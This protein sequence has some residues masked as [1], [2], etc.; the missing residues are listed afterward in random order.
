[1]VHVRHRRPHVRAVA[2]LA[3]IRCLYVHRTLASRIST[4]VTTNAVVHDIGMV[5]VRRHP[6]HGRMA[7]IAIVA[8]RNMSRVFANGRNAIV[9]GIA[10]AGNLRVV[11]NVHRH[12]DIGRMAVFADICG[13]Y[14]GRVLARRVCAIVTAGAIARDVHVIEIRRQPA[15]CGMTVVTIIAAGYVGRMLA[16][17]DHTVMAGT[18]SPYH[19]G[20]VDG[21]S[22]SP[23]VRRVAVFA[24]IACLNMGERFASRFNAV[25]A[26]DTISCDV[27]MIEI[28]R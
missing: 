19:L 7:V 12:P 14:V 20:V 28:C 26:T 11:D 18:T 17:R 9:A 13:L 1:V 2:V 4:V 16:S 21:K 8:A 10:G 27:H 3:N 6:G 22:G 25:M 24:D 5:E 23:Q 15:D